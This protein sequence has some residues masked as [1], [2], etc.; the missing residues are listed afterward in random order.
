LP[1]RLLSISLKLIVA[2]TECRPRDVEVEG[3]EKRREKFAAGISIRRAILAVAEIAHQDA[4]D[5]EMDERLWKIP[6]HFFEDRE[7][8]Q[9]FHIPSSAEI[10]RDVST[11]SHP[12][13]VATVLQRR[14]KFAGELRIF[15]GEYCAPEFA[16]PFSNGRGIV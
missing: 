1:I 3:V 16:H 12:R 9:P 8:L 5:L 2:R 14:N 4:A 13:N 6:R 15:S 11:H 10:I 7:T